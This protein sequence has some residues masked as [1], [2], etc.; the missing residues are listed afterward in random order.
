LDIVGANAL[1]IGGSAKG[2]QYRVASTGSTDSSALYRLDPGLSIRKVVPKDQNGDS[3][4]TTVKPLALWDVNA[5]YLCLTMGAYAGQITGDE[6]SRS[7]TGTYVVRKRDGKAIKIDDPP[8]FSERLDPVQADVQ[9]NLYYV[10]T[11]GKLVKI[12]IDTQEDKAVLKEISGENETIDHS[13]AVD[14]KGH[15]LVSGRLLAPP[16]SNGEPVRTILGAVLKIYKPDGS[17]QVLKSS[18]SAGGG[19]SMNM[20]KWRGENRQLYLRDANINKVQFNESNHATLIEIP[21]TGGMSSHPPAEP[22]AP[23]YLRVGSKH[24]FPS[25]RGFSAFSETDET[26]ELLELAQ[27][28]SPRMYQVFKN[29]VYMMGKN[30]DDQDVIVKFD[31]ATGRETLL[32]DGDPNLLVFGFTVLGDDSLTLNTMRLSDGAYVFG[33]LDSSGQF[34]PLS[35]DVQISEIKKVVVFQ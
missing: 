26:M 17:S 33:K 22:T 32:Y 11:I 31:L 6:V 19:S 34:S 1:F 21:G 7:L 20:L 5:D 15:V 28:R 8:T 18:T 2:S 25:G 10:T 27:I 4:E 35:T 3:I 9:G 16:A 12:E 24:F 13:F 23:T 29:N 30:G 14:D